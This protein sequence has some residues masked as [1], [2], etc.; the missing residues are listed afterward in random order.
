[1]PKNPTISRKEL[2]DTSKAERD[3]VESSFFKPPDRKL[4]TPAHVK[5]LDTTKQGIV[6]FPGMDLVVKFGPRV[7]VE[8]A[9]TMW[10]I[11]KLFNDQ[12]PVPELF[13]W[14]SFQNEIFIYMELIQGVTMKQRWSDPGLSDPDRLSLC[15]QLRQMI[16]S[17]R[18][19]QH[20]S[21]DMFIGMSRNGRGWYPSRLRLYLR[22]YYRLTITRSSILRPPKSWTFR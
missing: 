9:V 16:S 20:E 4:P 5:S 22:V 15:K 2:Q 7:T 10:A 8:E 12:I 19:L 13:G 1:M 3:F 11:T 18:Q 14:R 17:L 21:G 6:M